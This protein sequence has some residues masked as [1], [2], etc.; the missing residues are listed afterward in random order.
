VLFPLQFS[1]GTYYSLL[2]QL[3]ICSFLLHGRK[4]E[5]KERKKK[6]RRRRGGACYSVIGKKLFFNRPDRIGCAAGREGG[7][8]KGKKGKGGGEKKGRYSIFVSP[9]PLCLY[10]TPCHA[11]P[12][13]RGQEEERIGR[14][15]GK[16]RERFVINRLLD[17]QLLCLNAGETS[18]LEDAQPWGKGD[19]KGGRRRRRGEGE[20]PPHKP[21]YEYEKL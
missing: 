10:G 4:T 15:K 11:T 1:N 17:E 6:K 12:D 13:Y 3:L 21:T 16:K 2:L 8:G 5:K 14:G 18:P 20:N 9:L 7:E 19:D